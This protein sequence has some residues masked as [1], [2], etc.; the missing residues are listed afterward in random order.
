M[1]ITFG[2]CRLDLGARRLFRGAL[3]V[4]LSPKAFDLLKALVENRPRALSKTE[5]LKCVWPGTFVSDAS[6]ARAVSEIREGVCDSAHDPRVVRTVHGY[7]YAFVAEVAGDESPT[8][9]KPAPLDRV[10]HYL[11]W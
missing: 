6:L 10:L 9:R 11:T 4:H 8:P 3:E 7:G 2:D 5:L 1:T